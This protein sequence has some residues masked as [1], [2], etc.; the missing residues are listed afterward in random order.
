MYSRTHI[1]RQALPSGVAVATSTTGQVIIARANVD[2]A[3]A[4]IMAA[5]T[6]RVATA[7]TTGATAPSSIP[8]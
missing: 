3:D 5:S 8:L 7:T 6:L 1:H 2:A 4:A